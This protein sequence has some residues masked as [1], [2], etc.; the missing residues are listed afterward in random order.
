M[1]INPS[2]IIKGFYNL[3]TGKEKELMVKRLTICSDCDEI[4]TSILTCKKCGCYLPA[5]ASNPKQVCPLKK[6]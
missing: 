6:W 1:K 5:K 3:A 2:E 4:E